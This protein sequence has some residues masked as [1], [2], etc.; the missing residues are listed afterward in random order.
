MQKIT[1]KI[2]ALPVYLPV[3]I[4][5][6]VKVA[7]TGIGIGA[8]IALLSELI[9]NYFIDPVFCRS[10]DSFAICAEGGMIAFYA[11][12][13]IV[14][15]IGVAIL[16]T[17]GTFRPLLIALAAA[18]ALWGVKDFLGGL[19]WLE[20]GAWVAAMFGVAYVLFYWL[21]RARSFVLSLILTIIAVAAVRAI[22]AFA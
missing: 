7:V 3:S 21:L 6:L 20:Y 22:F 10:T 1:D 13:V 14:S 12:T 9:A 19:H 16:A 4:K 2:E 18:A 5:E 11:A 8:T 15:I 17:I